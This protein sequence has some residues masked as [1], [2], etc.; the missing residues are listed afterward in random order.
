ML[1]RIVPLGDIQGRL[2]I[3]LA[4]LEFEDGWPVRAEGQLRIAQL[5]TPLLMPGG[6]TELISLGDYLVNL[7]A[8]DAPGINGR[9]ED[10]GGP[11]EVAGAFTLTPTRAYDFN[12][13]ARARPDA[14]E[15]IIQALMF[16]P[17]ASDGSDR[18]AFELGGTL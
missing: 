15:E 9:F 12:G 6:P 13:L 2:S 11:L 14:P 7:S 5:K 16:L 4:E 8:N 17:T 1:G 18:R 10:Q 3:Q